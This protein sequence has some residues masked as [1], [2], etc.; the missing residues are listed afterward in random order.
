[1]L[2]G[3]PVKYGL[4]EPFNKLKIKPQNYREGPYK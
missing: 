2:N 3:L 4:N 1:M